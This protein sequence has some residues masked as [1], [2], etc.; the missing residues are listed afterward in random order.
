MIDQGADDLAC[1]KAPMF[2]AVLERCRKIVEL[3][4]VVMR[5]VW[6]QQRGRLLGLCEIPLQFL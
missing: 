6:V 3:H 5:H 1:F 2:I 4:S